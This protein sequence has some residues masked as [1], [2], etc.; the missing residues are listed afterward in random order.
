MFL[1]FLKIL[2]VCVCVCES[3][4]EVKNKMSHNSTVHITQSLTTIALYLT[5][6]TLP[7]WVLMPVFVEGKKNAWAIICILTSL[8]EMPP[9][10]EI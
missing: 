4:T 2:G 9:S 7:L 6:T 10:V 8:I 1:S 3:Y 5:I